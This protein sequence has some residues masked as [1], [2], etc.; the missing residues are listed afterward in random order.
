MITEKTII[1][2]NLI[3][4][5]LN[6]KNAFVVTFEG[7]DNKKRTYEREHKKRLSTK[8]F[9]KFINDLLSYDFITDKFKVLEVWNFKR[10]LEFFK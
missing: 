7:S 10:E 3:M 4:N 1:Q 2:P 8:Q 5:F 6:Y 9:L